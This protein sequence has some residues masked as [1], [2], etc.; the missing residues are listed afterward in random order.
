MAEKLDQEERKIRMAENIFFLLF[1]EVAIS[2]QY[3]S[4]VF[5]CACLFFQKN[6]LT[7]LVYIYIQTFLLFISLMLADLIINGDI[8]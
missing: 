2:N 7:I 3:I 8:W 6:R 5:S 4:H 1:F